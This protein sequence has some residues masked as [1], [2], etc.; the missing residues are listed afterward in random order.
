MKR[1]ILIGLMLCLFAPVIIEAKKNR[2]EMG[3]F[4]K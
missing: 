3:C 4:G 1:S 2:L